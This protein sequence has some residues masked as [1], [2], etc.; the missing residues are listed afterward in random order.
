MLGLNLQSSC[1]ILSY[2]LVE[3]TIIGEINY[4]H[5]IEVVDRNK[6][7]GQEGLYSVFLGHN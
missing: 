3:A 1:L 2:A 4:S 6:T 7:E 5:S